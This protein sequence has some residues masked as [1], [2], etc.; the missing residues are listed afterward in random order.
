MEQEGHQIGSPDPVPG[1][2]IAELYDAHAAQ[3]LRWFQSRTYSSEVA[4]DL[5]AETFATAI[6]SQHSFDP[7]RGAAG[8]WLWGIGRNL[9]RQY[10]RSAEVDRRARLRL[11]ITTP[12]VTDDDLDRVDD[13]LDAQPL[14]AA[15]AARL[16]DLPPGQAAAV[17]ARVLDGLP[18]VEVAQR[19]GCSVGAARVRVSRGL[20]ELLGLFEDHD[21]DPEVTP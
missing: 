13:R 19:C 2:S 7:E 17:R 4:A 15:L 9:L 14:A 20:V 6:E 10:L 11:G 8:A 3:L 5:C 1:W 18:Y 16:D 12:H 21:L